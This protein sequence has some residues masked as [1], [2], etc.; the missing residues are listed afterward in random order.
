MSSIFLKEK[1]MS[2][3]EEIA[4]VWNCKNKSW[5]FLN[6]NSVN[7]IITKQVS[8]DEMKLGF[9]NRKGTTAVVFIIHQLQEKYML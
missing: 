5:R 3:W 8:F 4:K 6:T 7:I 9:I 1:R 2:Y